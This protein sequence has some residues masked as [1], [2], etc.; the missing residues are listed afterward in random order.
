MKKLILNADD[1][2]LTPGVSR[3]IRYAFAHGALSSTTAIMNLPGTAAELEAAR[4]ET[5][6]LPVGIHLCLTLGRPIT[7]PDE[8]PSLVDE[9]GRFFDRRAFLTHLESIRP[10]EAGMEWRAQIEALLA[11]EISP[12]HLDSHHFVSYLSPGLLESMLKLAAEYSLPVR[13]PAGCDMKI[14]VLFPDLPVSVEGFL[15]EDAPSIIRR[16]SI[17][18]P[19]RLYIGFYDKTA[20]FKNLLRI[21]DGVPDGVSEIICH[22]GLADAELRQ[23]SDYAE[24]RGYELGILMDS[25]LPRLLSDR[26]I[27]LCGYSALHA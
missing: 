9:A 4:R 25:D 8:I 2:G 15:E 18:M 26:Q 1:Y 24:E 23:I 3:G 6:A 5:P 20:T 13:P 16:A 7:P 21:F 17:M 11:K 14:T 12:D 22:P 10:E 27:D 19:D